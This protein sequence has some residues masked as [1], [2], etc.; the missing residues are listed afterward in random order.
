MT[1]KRCQNAL[2]HLLNTTPTMVSRESHWV[3]LDLALPKPSSNPPIGKSHRRLKPTPRKWGVF[4]W[5]RFNGVK[6]PRLNIDSELR[7]PVTLI[8]C[9]SDNSAKYL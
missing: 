4:I 9:V 2:L 5:T 3:S 6:N 7:I 8:A 1:T